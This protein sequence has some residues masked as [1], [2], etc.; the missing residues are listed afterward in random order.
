L[1]HFVPYAKLGNVP[2][3]VSALVA[4]ICWEIAK[5]ILGYYLTHAAALTKVYGAYIFVVAVVLWIYYSSLIFILGAEIGQLYR[6][7]VPGGKYAI[8]L[9]IDSFEL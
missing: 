3:A 8:D 4:A 7:H 2:T 6:E 5:E 1:Y 9:G